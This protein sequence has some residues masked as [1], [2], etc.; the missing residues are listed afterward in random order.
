MSEGWVSLSNSRKFHY[1]IDKMTLCKKFLYMGNTFEG[2][3][4]GNATTD[5]C[6]ACVKNLQKMK[7]KTDEA[8]D[9]PT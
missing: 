9:A 2:V 1:V 3:W 7:P 5:D 6:A 4:T 8:K